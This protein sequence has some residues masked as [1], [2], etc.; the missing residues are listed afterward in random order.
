MS[1]YEAVFRIKPH[2]KVPR[3]P[4]KTHEDLL[5]AQQ[6]AHKNSQRPED[7]LLSEQAQKVKTQKNIKK[8]STET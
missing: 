5:E 4:A 3:N 2:R 7:D 6:E 1:P 8:K